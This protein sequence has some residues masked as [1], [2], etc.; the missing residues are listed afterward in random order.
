MYT[1]HGTLWEVH[2][3]ALLGEASEGGLYRLAQDLLTGGGERRDIQR[4]YLYTRDTGARSR[5]HPTDITDQEEKQTEL[6]AHQR[7]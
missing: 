1:P 2:T 5:S 6:R 7:R 4:V 3:A